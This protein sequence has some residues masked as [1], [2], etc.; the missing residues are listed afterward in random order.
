MRRHITALI[1]SVLAALLVAPSIPAAAAA[2]VKLGPVTGLNITASSAPS[3]YRLSSSW[4][5]LAG[6]TSYKAVLTDP[7]GATLATV[8]TTNVSWTVDVAVKGNTNVKVT[9][10]PYATKKPGVAASAIVTVPDLQAP[11][12]VF[13]SIRPDTGLE[14]TI[15]QDSLN[16]D[17]TPVAD[18]KREVTW[19]DGS[20]AQVWQTGDTI[21]HIYPGIGRYV[22]T[23]T[24]TDTSGNTVTLT[25]KAIV[26]G[27]TTAPTGTFAAGPAKAIAAW[28][29]VSLAQTALA[30]DFS[31]VDFIERVVAW[32]DGTT[33][34][35]ATGTSLT[36]VYAAAGTYEPSVTL[37]DEA[38][39]SAKYA[40]GTVV[41]ARDTTAPTVKITNRK[42]ASLAKWRAVRGT[43]AD[44]GTGVATVTISAIEKTAKG[45]RAY[46]G[47]RWVKASTK[48]QAWKRAKTI[49]V[50]PVA[51]AWKVRLAKLKKGKLLVRVR[52]VDNVGN[53]TAVI[54]RAQR[55]TKA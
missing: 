8:N 12:G 53:R 6:A 16:D 3:G 47:G 26:L 27:D 29:K 38:G 50:R 7:A 19:G 31:L 52:G 1:L 37:V 48:A 5:A 32:G 28:S 46:V 21:A 2:P 11:V 22:P 20:A 49:S 17:A 9:V 54:G 15:I 23:V 44:T 14:G 43:A 34:A 13:R 30:D 18:I 36:H 55:L 39:N 10:T 45:W 41:V 35:W 24:L 4:N 33:S 51:G 25:L 42:S 40:A